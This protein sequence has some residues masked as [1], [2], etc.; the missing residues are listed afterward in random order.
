[1]R[2]LNDPKS[3]KTIMI[4]MTEGDNRLRMMNSKVLAACATIYVVAQSRGGKATSPKNEYVRE[5]YRL[6]N[7]AGTSN[8]AAGTSD[9]YVRE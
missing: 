3:N 9:E 6:L 4:M 1:M 2:T 8:E 7:L 5:A